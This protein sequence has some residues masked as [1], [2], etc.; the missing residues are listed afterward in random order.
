LQFVPQYLEAVRVRNVRPR[1]I[2]AYREKLDKLILP[3]IGHVRL[4]KLTAA[5]V[6]KL[7]SEKLD[8][9]LS[10]ATVIMIH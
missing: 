9:G 7:Y 3:A 10:S 1:T 4:A 8:A 2:E 5:Q 6:D